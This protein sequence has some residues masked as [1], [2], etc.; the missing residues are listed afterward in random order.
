MKMKRSYI[1]SIVILLCSVSASYAQQNMRT[2]Y[3]LDGYTYR[4]KMNPAIQGERG[5]LAIPALGKVGVGVESNLGLS[6]FLYPSADG[7]LK[8]FLHPDVTDKEFLDKMKYG[9]LIM[10]NVDLPVL[11]LGFR[12]GKAYHTLDVSVRADA[13]ANLTKDL[14]SFIKSGSS[15]GVTSWNLSDFGVRGK[16]YAELAYGLSLRIG[17]KVTVGAR[18]KMLM[19]LA[20]A[21]IAM[22]NM[23]LTLSGEE[24]AVNA[25]GAASVAGPIYLE[26]D[27]NGLIDFSS[28]GLQTEEEIIEYLEDPAKGFALDLGISADL[29]DWLTLSASVTDLGKVGWKNVINAST[30]QTSWKFDGFENLRLEDENSLSQ[31]LEAVVE[32]LSDAVNIRK[33]GYVDRVS[34]K[35]SATAY[36]G[37][38]ARLPF[39]KRL[40]VGALGTHHMDGAYSWSEARM[41][42]NWALLRI[43]SVSG[44]YAFSTIGDSLGAAANIHLPGLTL[45][46]GVDSF[47]PLMNMTPSYIPIDACNT[48]VTVG[49]NIAFGKYRGRYMREK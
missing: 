28:I 23:N 26:T 19:G 46:A 32:G 49:L 18:A 29:L 35:L 5:F 21:D 33:D 6:T 44:S 2:G 39:Y 11:A 22:E 12:T 10:T 3:F 37:L 14:F 30:P 48:N 34:E 20:K 24:W 9:N 8:T 41:S 42:V 40:T 25:K 38:E 7:T 13:D 31:E 47:L 4:Y 17:E 1:L 15:E 36:L 45:Y 27:E 43:F 16:A